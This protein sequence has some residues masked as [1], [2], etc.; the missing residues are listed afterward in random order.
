[1]GDQS[2]ELSFAFTADRYVRAHRLY[3]TRPLPRFLYWF[4]YFFLAV[5][6]AVAVVVGSSTWFGLL[7]RTLYAMFLVAM[8]LAVFVVRGPLA[9]PLLK[10]RFR[11][12][13]D[14]DRVMA[15]VFSD[16]GLHSSTEGL[17]E[18]QIAW[19]MIQEAVIAKDA[20]LLFMTPRQYLFVA[21][22]TCDDRDR[23]V[24]LVRAHVAKSKSV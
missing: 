12:R 18:S 7:P 9:Y 3:L 19:A 1:M 10:K 8:G 15:H 2:L 16:E 21:L 11:K 22:D 13:P 24:E 20:M 14:A 17:A 6:L 4:S 5:C 23:I